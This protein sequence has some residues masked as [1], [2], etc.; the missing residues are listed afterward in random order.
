MN[1]TGKFPISGQLLPKSF[2][3]LGIYLHNGT[4]KG[5]RLDVEVKQ[6][7][8]AGMEVT[9]FLLAQLSFQMA[10]QGHR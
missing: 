8:R 10:C 1:V 5:E 2:H 3:Y 4:Q 9:L 7:P 6:P